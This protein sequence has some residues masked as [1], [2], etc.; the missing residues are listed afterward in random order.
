MHVVDL[1]KSDESVP[2][3]GV[4]VQVKLI[5]LFNFFDQTSFKTFLG[6]TICEALS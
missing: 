2:V 5:F 6:L 3:A 1:M 4:G